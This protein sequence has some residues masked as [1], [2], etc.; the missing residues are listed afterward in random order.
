IERCFD[1][2]RAYAGRNSQAHHGFAEFAKLTLKLI[3]CVTLAC[4]TLEL[5]NSDVLTLDKSV[6]PVDHHDKP[7]AAPDLLRPSMLKSEEE[8]DAARREN[9]ILRRQLRDRGAFGELVGNSEAM[10]SVYALIEQVASS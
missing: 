7:A 5:M 6:A 8:L 4:A 3:V 9:E 10:Q 1:A 2:G